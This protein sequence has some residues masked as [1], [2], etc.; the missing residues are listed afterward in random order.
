MYFLGL[1][2]HWDGVVLISGFLVIPTV[3]IGFIFPLL[4]VNGIFLGV[5]L[6]LDCLKLIVYYQD[7]FLCLG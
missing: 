1:A 2:A 4:F 5:N 3:V 7:G 6:G